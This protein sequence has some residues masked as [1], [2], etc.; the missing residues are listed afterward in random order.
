MVLLFVFSQLLNS[1][2]NFMDFLVVFNKIVGL[3]HSVKLWV[4][5]IPYYFKTENNSQFF[6]IG[7]QTLKML[8]H[9]S[10]SLK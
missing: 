2:R 9:G 3:L 8:L 1:G 10:L 5:S 4:N 7:F 6:L